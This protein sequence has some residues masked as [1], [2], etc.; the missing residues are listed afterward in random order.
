MEHVV[1]DADYLAVQPSGD[2]A[3]L[4]PVEHGLL[5]LSVTV[6]ADLGPE[7][8]MVTTG[9]RFQAGAVGFCQGADLHHPSR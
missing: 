6:V 3:S 1:R 4:L 5:S 9:Q 7:M 8:G 2:T